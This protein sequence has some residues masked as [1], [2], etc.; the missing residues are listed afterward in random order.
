MFFRKRARPTVD[1]KDKKQAAIWFG[2]ML[3][4]GPFAT[5]NRPENDPEVESAFVGASMLGIMPGQAIGHKAMSAF[6]FTGT[7]DGGL[8]VVLDLSAS[9]HFKRVEAVYDEKEGVKRP[10]SIAM[11]TQKW[12]QEVMENMLGAPLQIDA[13]VPN[14]VKFTIRPE[15]VKKMSEEYSRAMQHREFVDML[16]DRIVIDGQ[17]LVVDRRPTARG[18]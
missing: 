13:C 4:A 15:L 14:T 12:A 8:Q 18:A 16:P 1:E 17:P 7:A 10:G 2:T 6:T 9:P 5:I 11:R 3:C